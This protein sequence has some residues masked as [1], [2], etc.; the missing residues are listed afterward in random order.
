MTKITFSS[1][2]TPYP[3]A[4][5][6]DKWKLLGNFLT[7]EVRSQVSWDSYW[8]LPIKQG[9]E[10]YSFTWEGSGDAHSID[11]SGSLA[12]L[13]NSY[14]SDDAVLEVSSVKLLKLVEDWFEYNKTQ[15]KDEITI[16]I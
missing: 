6:D 13:S 8:S 4:V 12:I 7:T 14:L 3:E 1:G 5:S 10:D 2:G 16:E 11:I 15:T 9:L